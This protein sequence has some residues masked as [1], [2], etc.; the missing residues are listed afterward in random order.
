M[1]IKDIL[2][3]EL[4]NSL[5]MKDRYE[6]ELSKLPVGSLAVRNIKGNKYA[7]RIYRDNGKFVAGAGN[8]PSLFS[9]L[10]KEIA[11]LKRAL[12]GKE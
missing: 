10:K 1:I 12:R 4:G 7:Y 9:E 11:F 5:R 3:E 2:N 6:Q 8:E